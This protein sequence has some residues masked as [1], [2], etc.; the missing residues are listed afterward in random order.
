[1]I[2]DKGYISSDIK[3]KLKKKGTT[4]VY[5]YRNYGK[6][7]KINKNGLKKHSKSYKENTDI[8]KNLLKNRYKIENSFSN[9][10]QF[11]RLSFVYERN[12]IYFK[13]FVYLACYLMN[14]NVGYNI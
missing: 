14:S 13:G 5:P 1:V 4:L 3:D 2:G 7:T 10:K 12:I 8:D 11:R 6:S 9:L